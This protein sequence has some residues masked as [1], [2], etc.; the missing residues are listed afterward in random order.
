[1]SQQTKSDTDNKQLSKKPDRKT[2]LV[3]L[4]FF[5]ILFGGV[6][7][8]PFSGLTVIIA[9]VLFI[10]IASIIYTYQF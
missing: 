1:M 2:L 10:F 6:I 3:N 5:T 4:V 8:I 7:I 9:V